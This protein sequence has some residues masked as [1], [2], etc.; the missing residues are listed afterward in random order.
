MISI[1]VPVYNVEHYLPKCL[2]S[3]LSQTYSNI[4]VVCV[5]DGSQDKSASILA[6]YSA[7][8][9]RLKVVTQPNSGIASARNRGIEEAQGE[10]IMFVD[11][12]DWIDIAT[13]E[14]ALSMAMEHCTD[15][16]LWAYTREL[17]NG[18][19]A[20]RLLMNEDKLFNENSIHLLHRRMVGPVDEELSDPSLLHS[21]GTVWGKL[22]SRDVIKPFRFVDTKIIGSAE[23]ALFN[24][25]VFTRVKSAFYINKVM[26]H[27]RK[28]VSSFTGGHNKSLNKCWARLYKMI[29]DTIANHHLPADFQQ[30]L[31]N[32]IA[33]GLIDQGMNECKSP[34]K[35]PDKIK[36]IKQIITEKQYCLAVQ[37][38][39]LKYF[40]LHWLFF[41]WAA[42][43]GDAWALY[44]LLNLIIYL[45]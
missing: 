22:Y 43:K 35:M 5:N 14:N 3:L 10:W 19:S 34:Q 37:S 44:V 6:N 28:N 45:I 18:K 29:S 33:I 16:V 24:I 39:P 42:K 27:Y 9:S 11:S 4:E 26:Y 30:A 41:F 8:D 25:E 7:K 1:I 20:P 23:D 36:A 13:C 2:D 17:V 32:R 40:P 38:L 21:W 31:H 15:V 12:D